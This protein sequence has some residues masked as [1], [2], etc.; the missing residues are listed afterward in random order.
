MTTTNRGRRGRRETLVVRLYVAGD[1]SNS[2]LARNNLQSA[3]AHLP[4]GDVRL[5]VV[6]VLRE[7]ERALEDGVLVTPTLI[8][9]SPLPERRVVGNLRDRSALMTGLGIDEVT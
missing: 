5:E 8:R 1:S 9:Q 2:Q 4:R 3:L 7:P 6:D